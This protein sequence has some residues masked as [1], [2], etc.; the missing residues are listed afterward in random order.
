RTQRRMI[1]WQN[2]YALQE[3]TLTAGIT[4]TRQRIDNDNGFGAPYHN[5]P[6]TRAVYLQDA[7]HQGDWSLVAAGRAEHDD[8]YGNYQTGNL[9]GSY[10]LNQQQ[11]LYVSIGTAFHAPDGQ[12]IAAA[13]APLDPERSRSIELGTKYSGERDQW[14]LAVFETTIRDLIGYDSAFNVVNIDSARIQGIEGSLR[15]DFGP[16]TLYGNA[17]YLR[18]I[19]RS[20]GDDLSRRPRRNLTVGLEQT[21]GAWRSFAEVVARSGS[22]NSSF[23]TSQL[24]G[25]ATVNAGTRYQLNKWVEL[26]LAADN[27]LDKQYGYAMTAGRTY[28][29]QPRQI[30][31]TLTLTY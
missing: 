2:N 15:H 21:R 17:S 29:A 19:D 20:T 1:D 24:P 11:K 22:D 25:F 6:D 4:Y 5:T 8:R 3:H 23:D 30:K 10:D 12:D 27:L 7:W 14:E 26:G 31:A 9:N 16:A 18:P 13:I 28:I